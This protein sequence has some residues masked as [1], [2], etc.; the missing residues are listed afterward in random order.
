MK[1][2]SIKGS[3]P[4]E[5]KAALQQAKGEDFVPTLA[6]VFISIKQDRKAV[7]EILKNEGIDIFG[8]TSCGEFIEGY[9][10]E[11]STVALL[12][13]DFFF[14]PVNYEEDSLGLLVYLAVG[15]PIL[16]LNMWAWG[17]PESLKTYFSKKDK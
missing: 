5:I 2:K 8:A 16:I 7:C 9:Q 12:L 14:H 1:A 4:E 6:I 10:G 3:S 13:D 11:G 15:I 17:A